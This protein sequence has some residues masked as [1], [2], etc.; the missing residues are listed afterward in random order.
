MGRTY[1]FAAPIVV[2]V[3]P[4]ETWSVAEASAP[5]TVPNQARR[6]PWRAA[7][8]SCAVRMAWSRALAAISFVA[9]VAVG[10]AAGVFVAVATGVFVVFAPG[11]AVGAA[12]V[13]GAVG[14]FV[15]PGAFAVGATRV[16]T[17]ATAAINSTSRIRA[18]IPAR[19]YPRRGFRVGRAD[20]MHVSPAK[21]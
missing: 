3:P 4:R 13:G 6:S 14:G 10:L 8:E 12:G 16:D 5:W 15:V 20:A 1:G 9:L 2:E 18:V 7:P 19:R 11:V 21:R 17:I